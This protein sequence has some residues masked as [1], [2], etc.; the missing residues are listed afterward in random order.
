MLV[1]KIREK[2][3]SVCVRKMLSLVLVI[4]FFWVA[5]WNSERGLLLLGFGSTVWWFTLS[6]CIA[7][8][9]FDLWL[10]LWFVHNSYLVFGIWYS[11]LVFVNLWFCICERELFGC[12][13][14]WVCE[15]ASTPICIIPNLLLWNLFVIACRCRLLPNHV[16]LGVL[17][18]FS[19]GLIFFVPIVS[20]KICHKPKIFLQSIL[21]N[22]N[23]CY[24]TTN[25]YQSQVCY[26]GIWICSLWRFWWLVH[27]SDYW[28]KNVK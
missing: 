2:E 3:K 19:F 11:Y 26:L 6:W 23:F 17:C 4:W 28:E 18:L 13:R 14:I 8:F 12:I 10:F 24:F 25:W 16:I 7:T 22:L 15:S 20:L 27:E 9:G 21:I 1:Q 5:I